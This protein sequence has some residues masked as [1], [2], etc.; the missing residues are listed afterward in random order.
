MIVLTVRALALACRGDRELVL[1]NMALRQQ[2]RA[3][4]HDE[5]SA[6]PNARPAVLEC[7]GQPVAALAHGVGFRPAGDGSA[8]ASRLSAPPMDA[9]LDAD[10]RRSPTDQS[11]DSRAD[12]RDDDV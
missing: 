11:R 6:P 9:A 10:V 2:L 4:T 3:F 5:A 8:M 1:E 12:P 7:V